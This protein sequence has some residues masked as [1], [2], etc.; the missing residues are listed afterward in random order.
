MEFINTIYMSIS[1]IKSPIMLLLIMFYLVKTLVFL[2]LDLD[3]AP[4]VVNMTVAV[5]PTILI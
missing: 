2:V 1:K 4:G 3:L 5:I